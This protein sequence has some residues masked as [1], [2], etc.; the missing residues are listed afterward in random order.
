MLV[1]GTAPHTL[2]PLL[3]GA[4][5]E[6]LNLGAFLDSS[7]LR[8]H[9]RQIVEINNEKAYLYQSAYRYLQCAGALGTEISEAYN[10]I[11]DESK[12]ALLKEEAAAE[13]FPDAILRSFKKENGR[14]MLF[15]EAYTA[16]GYCNFTDSFSDGKKVIGVIGENIRSVSSLLIALAAFAESIGLEVVCCCMPLYPDMLQHLIIPKL[17]VL[18]RSAVSASSRD[19]DEI[20]DMRR[21]LDIEKL[22]ACSSEIEDNGNIFDAMIDK[23]IKKLSEARELHRQLETYYVSSMDFGAADRCFEDV[24]SRCS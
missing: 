3:P 19:F 5:D 9:K 23:A 1:D 17:N 20:I 4:A 10:K 18:I 21:L 14:R 12:L 2:D 13:V 8:E 6:I 11:T 22:N 16:D 7:N 15:T 24:I